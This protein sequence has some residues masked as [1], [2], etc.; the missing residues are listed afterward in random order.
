MPTQSGPL[1]FRVLIVEDSASTANQLLGLLRD[2]FPTLEVDS[3]LTQ[4]EA[5][6]QVNA[7]A[8]QH[9]QYDLVF[10]DFKLPRRPGEVP[11]VNQEVYR[12][13]RDRS[14][15]S[16]VVHT[17][18]YA[19]DPEITRRILSEATQAPF[20]PRSVFLS[21][22]DN[23][24]TKDL[25]GIVG[26]A[27]RTRPGTAHEPG[28]FQSCFISYSH[29]DELFVK[30]LYSRLKSEGLQLWYAAE[31]MR[32]GLKI[33]EEIEGN[34]RIYDK[35]LL[36]LS[37]S[38]MSSDWVA[39]EIRTAIN[40][41]KLTGKR[42]LFPVRLVDYDEIVKWKVFNADIGIDMAAE[43]REYFIPDFS[44]WTNT[45]SFENQIQRLLA[46]LKT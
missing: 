17:S 38:S 22:L 18:A 4:D 2:S 14:A 10:L 7:A 45:A 11:E 44:T 23:S 32:P 26:D 3:A 29:A 28:L 37:R 15:Q 35:L 19:H 33:H 43:L 42:K 34:I 16:F 8:D 24:W 39:A 6:S 40:E 20:R 41:E 1:S 9:K 31:H 13:L 21:K 27:L 25:V 12:T 46:A 30:V 5:L 36:V